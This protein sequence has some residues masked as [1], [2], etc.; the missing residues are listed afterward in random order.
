[1]AKCGRM[2]IHIGPQQ[3]FMKFIANFAH[4]PDS[5]EDNAP[6][7]L[8]YLNAMLEVTYFVPFHE[9]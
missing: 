6:F 7:T 2:A 9:P 8:T 5:F 4:L 1:M 3:A